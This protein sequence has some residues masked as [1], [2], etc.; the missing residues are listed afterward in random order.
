MR[1][2]L[3]CPAKF[4]NC[5]LY[6]LENDKERHYV[7]ITKLPPPQRLKR[8]N[9]GDVYSTKFGKPW[10]IIYLERYNNYELARQREKQIK[11]WHGG[12]AFKKL[13][14]EAAG[15]SNG[16]IVDSESTR[17]G[18]NPSPAASVESINKNINLAG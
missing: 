14:T 8:H 5:F 10:R 7:G 13:V 16:R 2:R 18:S 1:D 4:M 15:S 12:N 11:S 6:I 17:L 9:D 3:T